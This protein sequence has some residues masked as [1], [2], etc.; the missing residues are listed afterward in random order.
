M[1]YCI[2]CGCRIDFGQ[3]KCSN[4]KRNPFKQKPHVEERILEW[5]DK[6]INSDRDL[7]HISMFFLAI[8]IIAFLIH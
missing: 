1:L 4:C 7:L 6:G 3:Q 5:E 2:N 8:L